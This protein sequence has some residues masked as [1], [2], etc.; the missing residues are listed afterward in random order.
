MDNIKED[1]SWTQSRGQRL[2]RRPASI[3]TYTLQLVGSCIYTS[4]NIAEK[5]SRVTIRARIQGTPL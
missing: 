2:E 4:G 3:T 5:G 1:R